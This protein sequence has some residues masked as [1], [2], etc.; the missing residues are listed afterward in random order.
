MNPLPKKGWLR[1]SLRTMLVGVAVI[2]L[3]LYVMLGLKDRQIAKRLQASIRNLSLSNAEMYRSVNR[4][5]VHSNVDSLSRPNVVVAHRGVYS[6]DFSSATDTKIDEL[7]VVWI[8]SSPTVNGVRL[9]SP[10]SDDEVDFA[11][12][13]GRLAQL[14][15]YAQVG[16]SQI[17]DRLL[18]QFVPRR[19]K[20]S[21]RPEMYKQ[22]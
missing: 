8:E 7:V 11:I 6:D 12:T 16:A 20:T 17:S 19:F 15:K 5:L 3:L 10:N 1:F 9:F 13:A 14:M 2:A 21:S 18:D 4:R 22:C